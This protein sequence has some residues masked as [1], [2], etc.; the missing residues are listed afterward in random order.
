VWKNKI[1]SFLKSKDPLELDVMEKGINPKEVSASDN[2]KE[3]FD[4]DIEKIN[5]AE[6]TK[7]ETLDVKTI[8]SLYCA[9]SP[10]EYNIISSCETAK[11]IC[12][13]LHI[14][15]EGTYRVNETKVNILLG[16]Y[17]SFKMKFRESIEDM[18]S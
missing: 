3:V 6:I 12:D 16:Q 9:L 17:E 14:T 15:Y 18:F 11:E 13:R 4:K 1:K 8:Y 7:R 5:Q 2:G 10:T